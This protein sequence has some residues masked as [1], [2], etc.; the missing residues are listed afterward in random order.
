LLEGKQNT[1]KTWLVLQLLP[2]VPFEERQ[3][4]IS[5]ESVRVRHREGMS[6]EKVRLVFGFLP[7]KILLPT[8]RGSISRRAILLLTLFV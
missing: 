4:R 1:E 5:P 8:Q 2:T 6:L 3:E 7:R